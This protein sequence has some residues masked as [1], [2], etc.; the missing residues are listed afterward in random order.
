M[1]RLRKV[2][3]ALL[4][5]G[6]IVPGAATVALA[7]S[8]QDLPDEAA[9]ERYRTLQ[10]RFFCQCGCNY[11]L[12]HC[13]HLVCPSAPVM[14]KEILTGMSAGLNDAAIVE[15]MVASFGTVA[16]SEP[17]HEGFNIIG[18]WMPLAAFLGGLALIYKV[19]LSWRR[20]T[21]VVAAP[22][23]PALLD[24]YRDAVDREIEGLE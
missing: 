16:L 8:P 4:L 11:I 2:G 22:R 7:Q 21:P 1:N 13:P 12:L 6:V 9:R 24:K 23:D 18:W 3:L 19:A 15:A 10:L 17:P 5:A 20:R 14:R